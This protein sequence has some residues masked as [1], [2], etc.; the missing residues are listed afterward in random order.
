LRFSR[1]FLNFD[2]CFL[3]EIFKK[4]SK[5]RRFFPFSDFQ[6]IFFSL[7]GIFWDTLG[8]AILQL[9]TKGLKCK[10]ENALVLVFERKISDIQSILPAL[11][12]AAKSGRP[13][14][15]LAEDVDGDALAALIL[16][17]LKGGL[18]VVAVKAPGFGDN[19]K[20]TLR[21]IAIATGAQVFG[22]EATGTKIRSRN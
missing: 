13:L 12:A 21:D 3:F 18:K 20:N 2:V 14:L 5:F 8:Y 6:E 1:N 19:R 10:Y 16:N 22:D 17:R 9:W 15:I 4:F 7:F 11:E